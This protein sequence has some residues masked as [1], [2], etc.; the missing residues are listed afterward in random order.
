[1]SLTEEFA[2]VYAGFLTITSTIDFFVITGMLAV[3]EPTLMFIVEE[4]FINAEHRVKL[5][6]NKLSSLP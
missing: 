4:F 3:I 2:L 5:R 1:V 6:T